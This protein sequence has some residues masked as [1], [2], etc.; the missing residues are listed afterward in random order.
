[1]GIQKDI[2]VSS[3]NLSLT[4]T[5]AYT[6]EISAD[7]LLDEGLNWAIVGHSERRSYYGETNQVVADKTKVAIDK[8]LSTITCIG[9]TLEERESGNM[10]NVLAG[11]MSAVADTLSAKD[12]DNVVVAY[13]PVWA[14]GTGVV[15]T[16]A[17]AQEAHTFLRAWMAKRLGQET[18]DKVRVL[19]GGSVSE[20]N[21][22]ELIGLPDVD[23]FLVGGASLKATFNDIINQT[24]DSA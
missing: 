8:G 13:E 12:W 15:A 16:P 5:G 4:G 20:K 21:C 23:G 6:G 1:M 7:H 19:Y 3:Q 9:E 18:S 2:A 22:K 11:Q 24:Q 17:Q 10:E 14:I